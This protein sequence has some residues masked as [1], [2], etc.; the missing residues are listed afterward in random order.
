MTLQV[1]LFYIQA[2]LNFRIAEFTVVSVMETT[3]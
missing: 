3:T 2:Q 1:L